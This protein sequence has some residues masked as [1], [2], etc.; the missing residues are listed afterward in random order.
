[1]KKL[2]LLSLATMITFSASAQIEMYKE[3][4]QV[5]VQVKKKSW[6]EKK[7]EYLDS[8]Q[9]NTTYPLL[10]LS[11]DANFDKK[12]KKYINRYLIGDTLYSVRDR[13][14]STPIFVLTSTNDSIRVS[15]LPIGEYFQ[16]VDM[17]VCKEEKDSLFNSFNNKTF[18]EEEVTVGGG[19]P[20]KFRKMVRIGTKNFFLFFSKPIKAPIWE[21]IYEDYPIYVLKKNDTIY[22]ANYTTYSYYFASISRDNRFCMAGILDFV[23]VKSYNM[24]KSMY[25]GKEF[26]SINT[27][28]IHGK[29]DLIRQVEASS[30]W[31][32]E[33][34]LLKGTDFYAECASNDDQ[35]KG[36][37]I[38]KI[39]IYSIG[40][41]HFKYGFPTTESDTLCVLPVGEQQLMLKSE[42]DVLIAKFKYEEEQNALAEKKRQTQYKNDI[43]KKYG[44]KY[45]SLIAQGKICVGMTQEMCIEAKGTPCKK[46]KSSDKY[47]T[48]EVWTYDCLG[49]EWA[50]KLGLSAN[51]TFVTFKNGKITDI[52]E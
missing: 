32:I 2:I 28:D 37:R 12:N 44:E 29:K 13:V 46:N 45:G 4:Q 19:E 14:E 35:K 34:L 23:S 16:V 50:W 18:V 52:T 8:I 33:K 5:Q 1:M 15:K 51:Y 7:K 9:Q 24:L 17:I 22:Y 11:K 27:T 25:V 31:T 47:G 20:F 3:E 42:A 41:N 21:A 43:I 49:V 26:V 10:S 39:S 6:Q 36:G 40:D 38:E 30:I 48:I